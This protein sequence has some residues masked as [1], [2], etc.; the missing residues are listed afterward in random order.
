MRA[1]SL[2]KLLQEKRGI[3]IGIG[4]NGEGE[5]DSDSDESHESAI[6]VGVGGLFV[7]ESGLVDLS[8]QRF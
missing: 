4:I 2:A 1:R 3:E 6:R 8:A 7:D 5:D